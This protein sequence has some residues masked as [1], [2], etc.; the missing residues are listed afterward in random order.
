MEITPALR[1][2]IVPGAE[3]DRIHEAALAE[4]MVP[5]TRHALQMARAGRISL[6]EA[7]RVRTD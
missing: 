4:G 1:R 2:L 6:A 5:I 3:A 7:Y